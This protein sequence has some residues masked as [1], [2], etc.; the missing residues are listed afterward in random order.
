MTSEAGRGG[1]SVGVEFA[2]EGARSIREVL[3]TRIKTAAPQLQPERET[4]QENQMALPVQTLHFKL[5]PSHFTL[6][7]SNHPCSVAGAGV[8]DGRF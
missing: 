2:R 7:T 5:H 8:D 1:C 4:P 6:Q 3:G